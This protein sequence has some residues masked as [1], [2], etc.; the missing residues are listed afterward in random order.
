MPWKPRLNPKQLKQTNDRLSAALIRTREALEISERRR[1]GLEIALTAR[2]NRIS[3]L[4][5]RLERARAQNR[6]LDEENDR[7]V[8]MVKLAPAD[9]AMPAPR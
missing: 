1:T 2:L 5:D 6:A 7:L 4:N 3:E 9:T 8:E